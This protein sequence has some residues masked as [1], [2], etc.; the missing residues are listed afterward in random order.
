M[1]DRRL[2]TL[3]GAALG[4][5]ALL[6][7]GCATD[8]LGSTGGT[9][10]GTPQQ[11]D[12]GPDGTV[13]FGGVGPDGDYSAPAANNGF[14]EQWGDA[15]DDNPGYDDPEAP[16]DPED[17]ILPGP[18]GDST[19]VVLSSTPTGRELLVLDEAG[20]QL[21]AIP[22]SDP[23]VNNIA[24]HPDG[25]FV[26]ASSGSIVQIDL[27]GSVSPITP[28]YGF[29]YRVNV[30]GGGDVDVAEED[31]VAS[32]DLQGNQLDS[33]GAPGACYMDMALDGGG[34]TLALDVWNY[35]VVEWTGAGFVDVI[36]DLP[37]GI[38]I[39]G[40]DADDT[41]WIAS[42]YSNELL[43]QDGS[44][45]VNL[46]SMADLG[47]PTGTIAAIEAADEASVYVLTSSWAGDSALSLVSE[48]GDLV[49]L[50]ASAASWMDMT[51]ID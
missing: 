17:P 45:V 18:I 47:Q 15:T 30:S 2:S 22:L 23:N 41:I 8:D 48:D 4:G 38:S 16:L 13:G 28:V 29:L 34:A 11:Q 39:F 12:S 46:G 3:L 21:D 7:A 31:Q 24:W 32:Y 35:K 50:A 37:S 33:L 10:P 26:G 9:D 49:T 44:T 43:V 27:A 19:L 51:R 20:N 40:R 36:T 5:A 1:A 14:P 42:G 25:F 6:V